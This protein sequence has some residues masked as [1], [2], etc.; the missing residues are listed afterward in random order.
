MYTRF[1]GLELSESDGK[2]YICRTNTLRVHISLIHVLVHLLSSSLM[3]TCTSP[4]NPPGTIITSALTRF[5]K[6]MDVCGCVWMRFFVVDNFVL[7]L[8]C[9]QKR[10]NGNYILAMALTHMDAQPSRSSSFAQHARTHLASRWCGCPSVMGV[11]SAVFVCEEELQHSGQQLKCVLQSGFFDGAYEKRSVFVNCC[12]RGRCCCVY[13]EW[14]A[15][16]KETFYLFPFISSAFE[17]I[18]G[19]C[20]Y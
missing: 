8:A 15:L 2:M 17:C 19:A 4:I 3:H 1:L 5:G 16:P 10:R 14:D 12:D 13:R 11:W 7:R 9:T 20:V 6:C 18:L